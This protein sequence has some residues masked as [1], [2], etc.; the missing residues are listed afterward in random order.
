[1]DHVEPNE[2][3]FTQGAKGSQDQ[4]IKW[5]SN[6]QVYT[7]SQQIDLA[8][9]EISEEFVTPNGCIGYSI[10]VD[11]SPIT[12]SADPF[13]IIIFNGSPVRFPYKDDANIQNL[14]VYTSPSFPYV[15]IKDALAFN[16]QLRVACTISI[17][18]Y[19]LK[20]RDR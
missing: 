4:F 10:V 12:A 20:Y 19:R 13:L 7:T 5:F 14:P 1:M 16:N 3:I 18:Y 15:E 9:N 6:K 17:I 11:P 2:I 8:I